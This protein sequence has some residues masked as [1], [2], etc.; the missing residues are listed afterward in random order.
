MLACCYF[1]RK[2]AYSCLAEYYNLLKC[3]HLM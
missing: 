2:P 1:T 3:R